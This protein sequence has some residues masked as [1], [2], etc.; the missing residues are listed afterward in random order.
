MENIGLRGLVINSDTIQ[1]AQL[2]KEDLW[3]QAEMGPNILFMA[4]E[5]LISKDFNDLIKEDG[6][7]AARVCAIAVDEVHLLNTWGKGWRKAFQQIGWV[8]AR[9]SNVVLIAM[10]ATMRG[11]AHTESV[12]KYLGLHRGRFH[13]IRRS[14]AHSDIQILFRTMKSG[15]GGRG[16]TESV[17]K[18]TSGQCWLANG[19]E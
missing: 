5:Q 17:R 16:Y 3:K 6:P 12:C 8:C 11:G 18:G 4:P 15:M 14:N 2:R 7:F 1:E 10:T 13:F 19:P 9:F